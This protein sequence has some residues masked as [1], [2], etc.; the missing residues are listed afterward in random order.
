MVSASGLV[1]AG[2]RRDL[3]RGADVVAESL[4]SDRGVV[5]FAIAVLSLRFRDAH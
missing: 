1:F 3:A 2:V 4:T 5:R